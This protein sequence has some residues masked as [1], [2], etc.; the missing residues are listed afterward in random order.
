MEIL[1]HALWAGAAGKA[2][3]LSASWRKKQPLKLKWMAFWGIFPDFFA[4][5]PAFA[6]MFASY[7]FPSLPKMYHPGPNNI[8]PATE[9]TLLISNL[10]HNLYNLSHSL[11]I[12]ILIFG[13]IWL[14]SKRPRWEIGGWMLHILI[15]I[16]THSY[17]FYPTPFLWPI[18]DFKINGTHWGSLQFELINYFLI[19]SAYVLLWLIKRTALTK[20]SA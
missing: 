17:Q 4:F 3:N 13:L 5:S 10:T 20:P 15:D 8:E 19:L 12:F 11:I 9:N 7:I 6:Y 2:I 1:S 16:P 14:I 18:S